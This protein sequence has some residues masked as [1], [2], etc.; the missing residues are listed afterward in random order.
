[1]IQCSLSNI[2]LS[3]TCLP[4]QT[5]C[6]PARQVV[7]ARLPPA[8]DD[9]VFVFDLRRFSLLASDSSVARGIVKALQ[10][11]YPERMAMCIL[12]APPRVFFLLWKLLKL[13]IDVRVHAKAR[14]LVCY[15]AGL[16]AMRVRRGGGP[17]LRGRCVWG[18]VGGG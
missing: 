17:G 3:S 10:T 13:L 9:G 11:A 8:V 1:M 12:Y 14:R 7:T 6:R 18:G 15:C 16:C 4:P 5:H 2:D